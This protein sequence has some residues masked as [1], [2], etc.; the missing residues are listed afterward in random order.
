M[1]PVR[2]GIILQSLALPGLGLSRMTGKP[3]WLRG[4]AGYGCIAGSI[5]LNRQAISTYDDIDDL[6]DYDDKN[7]LF[8]KSLN[9][10]N[11][12]EVLAYAA[13]GIWVDIGW[14]FRSQDKTIVQ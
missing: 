12:S 5:I 14:H 6:E 1:I 11:I 2:T 10:D 7:E 3:H 9:R 8:Q 4:V 13:I